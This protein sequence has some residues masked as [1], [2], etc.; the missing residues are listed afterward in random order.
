MIKAQTT[1]AGRLVL[2]P[3]WIVPRYLWSEGKALLAGKAVT[4]EVWARHLLPLAIVLFWLVFICKINM[5]FYIFGMVYPG[6]SL[7]LLRS[8]AEHRAAQEPKHRTAIVE[9][10]GIFGWLFLFNNLHAVHHEE[11]MLPWYEIPQWYRTNR[12][13]LLHENGGLVYNGYSEIVRRFLIWSHD[14]P[15][16]PHGRVP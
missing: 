7:M 15:V 10:A 2:G 11:P 6:T 1:L 3:L 8:F 14:A 12:A 5:L 4:R 9:N 13:R 16:H